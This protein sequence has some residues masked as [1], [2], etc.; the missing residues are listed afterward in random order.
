MPGIATNQTPDPFWE[1]KHL[2]YKGCVEKSCEY[3][4]GSF[5]ETFWWSLRDE[6]SKDSVIKQWANDPEKAVE[7][8]HSYFMFKWEQGAR[9][10]RRRQPQAQRPQ[11][12]RP[13][14]RHPRRKRRQKS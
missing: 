9:H 14:T 5:L 11:T 12:R 7:D 1:A 6:L 3:P 4:T 10:R 13:R 2:W 8:W